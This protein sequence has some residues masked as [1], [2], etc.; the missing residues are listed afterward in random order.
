M[1]VISDLHIH[2]RFARGTSK[3]LDIPNLE[4]WGRIKGL[5]LIGTGDFTYPEWFAELK[6]MLVKEEDGIYYT[7]TGY[8]FILQTE[9]S[10]IYTQDDKGRRVH[11]LVYAPSLEVVQQITDYLKRHGRV[12]Y[13]GRPIFK[14]PCY[15]FTEDLKKIDPRIEIVPAHIW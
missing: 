3:A 9:I 12:D 15:Q 6:Q 11:V 14:I 7:A 13:D 4:K 8:P 2:S 10:L 5:N 1:K